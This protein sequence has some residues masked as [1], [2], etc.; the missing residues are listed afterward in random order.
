MY[1]VLG[2]DQ[3]V[4]ELKKTKNTSYPDISVIWTQSQNSQ[5]TDYWPLFY[6][7]QLSTSLGYLDIVPLSQ[8]TQI[9]EVHTPQITCMM[10]DTAD[11]NGA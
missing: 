4:Y 11:K 2:D 6:S 9:T 10:A 3:V 7:L 8:D 1:I 5:I